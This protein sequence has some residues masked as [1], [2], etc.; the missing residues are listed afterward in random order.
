MHL[1]LTVSNKNFR[2][3]MDDFSI[4]YSTLVWYFEGCTECL[5]KEMGD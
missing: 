2:E 1:H 4:L 3:Q 5:Y